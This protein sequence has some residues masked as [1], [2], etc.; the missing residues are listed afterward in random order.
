MN[1]KEKK[2]L[3]L[4]KACKEPIHPEARLCP[5]CSTYQIVHRWKS[6]LGILKWLGGITAVLSLIITMV[7]VN[8]LFYS[9]RNKQ[10]AINQLV[11]VGNKQREDLDYASAWESY[12]R[13]LELDPGNKK[14]L[15]EQFELAM[16]WLRDIRVFGEQ[17]LTEVADKLLPVLYRGTVSKTG[18]KQ[19]SV[20]AHIAWANYLRYKDS[21]ISKKTIEQSFSKAFQIDPENVYTNAM[22]AFWVHYLDYT[23]SG[24]SK[25]FKDIK[26]YFDTALQTGEEREFVRRLQLF[27]LYESN[28]KGRGKELIKVINDLRKDS[29]PVNNY[30]NILVSGMQKVIYMEEELL[31][32]VTALPS[33]EVISSL[34]YLAGKGEDISK[35]EFQF[36]E[37]AIAYT[38]EIHGDIAGAKFI[39]EKLKDSD[40]ISGLTYKIENA[41]ERLKQKE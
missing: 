29:V 32:M 1:T 10:E 26:K 18:Y 35:R 17:T 4:C 15:K 11:L 36:I 41:L 30:Q 37:Y 31:E 6:F 33:E 25:G 19:A 5:H 14:A 34:E 22:Y 8:K 2:G 13:V 27:W 24:A 20:Y 39:Y 38:K 40:Y 28:D 7:E 16:T 21:M 3:R 12:E 9:W 23:R